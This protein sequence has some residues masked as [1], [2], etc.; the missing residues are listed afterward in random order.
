MY[1]SLNC[2]DETE[3]KLKA[4]RIT[5]LV[6][7]LQSLISAAEIF[8]VPCQL[9]IASRAGMFARNELRQK[10]DRGRFRGQ[11]GRKIEAARMERMGRVRR[12]SSGTGKRHGGISEIAPDIFACSV[13]IVGIAT[14]SNA[15]LSLSSPHPPSFS[16]LSS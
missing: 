3:A 14:A 6:F 8:K 1:K 12:H 7:K 10:Q 15:S 2:K 13:Y 11:S 9:Y 4:V 5:R 16:L